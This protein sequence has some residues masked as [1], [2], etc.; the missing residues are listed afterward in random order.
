MPADTISRTSVY[1]AL[2]L[3]KDVHVPMRD[4]AYVVADVFRPEIDCRFPI[5]MTMGPYSKDIHFCEWNPSLDYEHL[6]ERGPYMLS[7][8]KT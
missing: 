7:V 3:D 2:K 4:G 1:Y 6:P 5:I 8:P